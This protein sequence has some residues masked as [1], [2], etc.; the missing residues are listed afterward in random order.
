MLNRIQA[1]AAAMSA[2]GTLAVTLGQTAELPF[3]LA[4][5]PIPAEVPALTARMADLMA[6][7]VRQ[8]SRSRRAQAQRDSRKPT[9]P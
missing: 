9:S 7:A 5:E 8:P 2:R 3:I 6:E 1:A 4:P